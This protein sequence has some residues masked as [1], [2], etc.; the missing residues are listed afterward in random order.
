MQSSDTLY[1]SYAT[2][3][4]SPALNGI[5]IFQRQWLVGLK[6]TDNTGHWKETS[7]SPWRGPSSGSS[8]DVPAAL[9]AES[10]SPAQLSAF[11]SPSPTEVAP[12]CSNNRRCNDFNFFIGVSPPFGQARGESIYVDVVSDYNAGTVEDL[13]GDLSHMDDRLRT[14]LGPDVLCQHPE[15][16]QLRGRM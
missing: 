5:A 9:P 4:R 11:S 8:G 13:F 2:A 1:A 10:Q 3:M 6:T 14:I 7:L 16:G 15:L 12:S